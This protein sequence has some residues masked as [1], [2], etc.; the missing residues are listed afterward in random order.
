MNNFFKSREL[1]LTRKI[2]LICLSS[3]FLVFLFIFVLQKVITDQRGNM[4]KT[5]TQNQEAK[6][7]VISDTHL[8]P[9]SMHDE[10]AAF[11]RMETTSAGKDLNHQELALT[12]FV[13]KALIEKPNA[14]IITG[15]LT[16]NGELES[17]KRLAE[18][19]K[20]LKKARIAFL[21]VPGN[22][23][24]NDG[25]SRTFSADKQYR[26]QEISPQEWVKIFKDSYR[27]ADHL[28]KNSLSYSVNLNND[29]R[30]L[31]LDTNV[32][33]DG[34][35]TT[36]PATNG[37]LTKSTLEWLDGEL[38]DAKKHKQKV[39]IFMHHNLYPHHK[40]IYQDFVLDN[41]EDLQKLLRKYDVKLVFSGH[42]HAQNIIGPTEECPAVDIATGSFCVA[43]ENYGE[44]TFTPNK[45]SYQ[46]HRFE[47]TDNLNSEEKAQMHISNYNEYLKKLFAKG[48]HTHDFK[49]LF[50]KADWK[51]VNEFM[52]RMNWNYFVGKSNYTK[53]EI[54]AQKNSKE[55][56]L[57]SKKIPMMKQYFA[58]F[59]DVEKDSRSLTISDN[60]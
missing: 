11:K 33:T 48:D 22:H 2:R 54:Q 20:P 37:R 53:E 45:V 8:I 32:Y 15:D 52:F 4:E 19:F 17:A 60:E 38:E 6:I 57:I 41:A 25:W 16:F 51:Q 34:Y 46:Y 30:F 3:I 36:A 50:A 39:V 9:A 18:I 24:I 55:F 59:W 28:D 21:V 40:M 10:G 31:M 56:K 49:N 5:I 7:W 44:T 13:R 58:G 27:Y 12:A 47:M 43:E 23:D 1:D 29:Y 26:A 42:I 14:V 35:S